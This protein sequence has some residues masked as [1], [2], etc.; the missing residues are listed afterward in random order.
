MPVQLCPMCQV[1][2][3]VVSSH[4]I[5]AALYKECRLPGGFPI[6]FNSKLAYESS[7]QMQSPLLCLDC[8]DV[9]NKGGENWMVPLF[10]R[11]DGSFGFHDLLTS[12]PPAVVD[13]DARGYF[14]ATNPQICSEKLIHFAMGVFWKAAVHAWIPGEQRS[15]IDLREYAEPIRRYLRGDGPYPSE[16]T[17]TVGILPKP[18]THLAI[19]VPY[20]GSNA[21]V[22]NFLF[23][24]VGIEFALLVGKGVTDEE[25]QGSLSGNPGRPIIVV[26]FSPMLRDITAEVMKTAHKARNIQKYLKRP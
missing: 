2:K 16:V 14:A 19:S 9:L 26:D 21:K 12:A 4:L 17:L 13:G 20:Q 10:A 24:A 15:L 22:T 8:E 6:V 23:Y 25:R 18:V 1:T 11:S 5:P 3:D 7:R